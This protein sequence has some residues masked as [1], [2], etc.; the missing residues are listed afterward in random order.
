MATGAKMVPLDAFNLSAKADCQIYNFGLLRRDR[1]SKAA[2]LIENVVSDSSEEGRRGAI[3][4]ASNCDFDI[5]RCVV[6]E[7]EASDD[8]AVFLD[9]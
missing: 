1:H 9:P 2:K 4:R 3:R 7:Y 8:F 6:V 5:E